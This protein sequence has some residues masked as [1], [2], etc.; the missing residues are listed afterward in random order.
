[1]DIKIASNHNKD[2]D[3][4]PV[5][6]KPNYKESE[7]MPLDDRSYSVDVL[8]PKCRKPIKRLLQDPRGVQLPYCCNLYWIPRW[9]LQGTIE[10]K[11]LQLHLCWF[12]PMAPSDKHLVFDNEVDFT[13]QTP[14]QTPELLE[15]SA[16][17]PEKSGDKTAENSVKTAENSVK[18]AEN[19][20]A[21]QST[22]T[23]DAESS[24]NN[25]T[26]NSAV[27]AE[28]T[29]HPILGQP[30]ATQLN[31]TQR[32]K[33]FLIHVNA[34]HT[35]STGEIRAALGLSPSTFKWAMDPLLAAGEVEKVGYGLYQLKR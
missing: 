12:R 27:S 14:E 11:T 9:K 3:G 4:S 25:S 13:Q 32:I 35:A 16:E 30:D 22:E 24:A 18:T 17:P 21:H 29:A 19:S 6:Q 34:E 33:E 7:T 8:C 23:A 1:M 31:A 26:Q 15:N 28:R 10:P 20:V 5:Y 2:I